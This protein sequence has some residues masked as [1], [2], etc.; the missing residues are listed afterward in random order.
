MK[1]RTRPAEGE[2]Q[3]SYE[4]EFQETRDVGPR[5]LKFGA[6]QAQLSIVD[7]PPEGGPVTSRSRPVMTPRRDLA[8]S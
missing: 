2:R 7:L 6:L 3:P 5:S 8:P 4:I 1:G